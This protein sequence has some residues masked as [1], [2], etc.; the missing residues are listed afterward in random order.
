MPFA[1]SMA[2]GLGSMISRMLAGRGAGPREGFQRL[3][4][5]LAKV[6]STSSSHGNLVTVTASADMVIKEIKFAP[7]FHAEPPARQQ[8]LVRDTVNEALKAVKLQGDVIADQHMQ[9]MMQEMLKSI[10]GGMMGSMFGG[11]KGGGGFGGFG[12]GSNSGGSG[13]GGF[14]DRR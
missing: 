9:Q 7:A 12:S 11:A 3:N 8:V 14:L 4:E 5:A 13:G 6:T 1:G 2:T 10:P